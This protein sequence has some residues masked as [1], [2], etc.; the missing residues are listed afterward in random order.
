MHTCVEMCLNMNIRKFALLY[1]SVCV[2]A[3][4]IDLHMTTEVVA[5]L[6]A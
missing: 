6:V 1:T 3:Y 4:F 2:Y 5:V